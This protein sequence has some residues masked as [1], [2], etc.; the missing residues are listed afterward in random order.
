[1]SARFRI[2]IDVGGTKIEGA[3]IDIA[4]L[5]RVRRRVATPVGDYRATV[6]TS[7]KYL[8]FSDQAIWL[9]VSVG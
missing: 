9:S 7:Q 6:K 5:V 1:M 4:G 2:G 3:A 8:K